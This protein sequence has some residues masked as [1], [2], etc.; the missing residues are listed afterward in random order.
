MGIPLKTIRRIMLT[1]GMLVSLPGALFGLLLAIVYNRLVF[2]AINGVWADIVRTEMM[3]IDIR[4]STMLTGFLAT[5]LVAWFSIFFPIS[6]FLKRAVTVHRTQRSSSMHGRFGKLLIRFGVLSTLTGLALIIIQLG[7]GEVINAG[8]FFPA[9][10]LLLLGGISLS[11]AFLSHG[12]G[13]QARFSLA[14]LSNRNARRN[15]GRSMSIVIL[16]AIGAFL[17]ISTGSNKKDLFV[18]AADASTGTG[19]FL[20]YAESTLPV[21]QDLNQDA[22]KYE[23]DITSNAS[24]IQLRISDGDDASCLNLNKIANPRILGV[25]PAQLSGRFSFE[26][27]AP[28]L[29]QEDPWST[30]NASLSGGL[31]PAI[32]DET[33]I[34]WGLGLSVG[35]TLSYKDSKGNRM[36]LLL[37]GGLAPSIF[38]GNVLISNQSFLSHFPQHSG[39]E[40]FL[41][42]GALKDS[43]LIREELEMGMRDLGWTMT[44]A[45]QR[46][47]EFNSVT[48]TYLSIFLVM[49]ALGLLLG[50]IGLAVVLYRSILERNREIALLRATG[51]GMR[52]I[53]KVI[54]REYLTLLLAGSGIG[55]LAAIVATLPS[56]LSPNTEV[57]FI[58]IIIVLTALV[59]NGWFWI[60]LLTGSGLRHRSINAALREE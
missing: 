21:L 29:N 53:R 20:Y 47:A 38:Q 15:R 27:A 42:E 10:G 55:F 3:S 54:I 12:K 48:N 60:W 40:V 34:K 58:T 30:L 25:N 51:Y 2:H 43:A 44:L 46:L 59:V 19:G 8:L 24:F 26:T 9:G 7:K 35:D 36:Q 50:T 22:V 41:V 23:Y 39:T 16:F 49:G 52:K 13:G 56:I 11:Y 28:E 6:S 14:A 45:A 17:V 37:V 18:N 1:E 32:A 31:I 4:V 33:V 5:L 57:S